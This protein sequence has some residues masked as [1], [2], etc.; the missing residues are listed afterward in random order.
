M[1]EEAKIDIL[2]SQTLRC[3]LNQNHYKFELFLRTWVA[4]VKLNKVLSFACDCE[5]GLP[6]RNFL[7]CSW[8]I[9]TFSEMNKRSKNSVR[10][11]EEK[12]LNGMK[13]VSILSTA[14]FL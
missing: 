10:F 5:M 14:D 1:N 13:I 9:T 11:T 6:M 7:L 3:R 4:F 8:I 2:K 12:T